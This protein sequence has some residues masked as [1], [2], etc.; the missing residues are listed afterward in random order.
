MPLRFERIRLEEEIKSWKRKSQKSEVFYDSFSGNKIS[1]RYE[2]LAKY[3]QET[4]S[5]ICD[6]LKIDFQEQMMEFWKHEHH[7]I[8]GNTGTKSLILKFRTNSF[9]KPEDYNEINRKRE[10][11]QIELDERWKRELT[12]EE[13]SFIQSKIVDF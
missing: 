1:L 8:A 12:K 9:L 3:P 7:H 10:Y 2:D 13:I 11:P 6:F 5:T 4:I